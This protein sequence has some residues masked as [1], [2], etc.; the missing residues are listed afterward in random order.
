MDFQ[1][2]LYRIRLKKQNKNGNKLEVKNNFNQ[3]INIF[4]NEIN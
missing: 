2:S 3:N 1:L 4:L